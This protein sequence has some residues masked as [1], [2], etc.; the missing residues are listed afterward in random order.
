MRDNA[1]LQ[2]Q[3]Q[4]YPKGMQS[5]N[6]DQTFFSYGMSDSAAPAGGSAEQANAQLRQRVFDIIRDAE[7][8]PSLALSEALGLPVESPG[9]VPSPRAQALMQIANQTG[10]KKPSV[11]KSALDELVKI[12]D[13]LTPEQ[14]RDVAK[15][16]EIY[17]ALGDEDG[18]K[19]ALKAL[20]K[21]A[22][23]VY[24]QDTDADDPNKAFKGVWPSVDMWRQ[25]V[26]VAGRISPDLAEEI[27]NEISD[28]DIVALEKVAFASTLLHAP[29]VPNL[30]N[31]CRKKGSLFTVSD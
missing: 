18:A 20:L 7:K 12:E 3:L 8:D 27:I 4:K 9:F 13:Q 22:E 23:K 11:T 28:P 21:A 5:L 19:K 25:C 31:D 17:L 6:S 26:Q 2:A 30:V 14:M 15:F 10:K 16:P 24:A 29:A 1:E